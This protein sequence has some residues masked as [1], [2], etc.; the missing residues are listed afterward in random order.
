MR[1]HGLISNI[2]ATA[3]DVVNLLQGYPTNILLTEEAAGD[4]LDWAKDSRTAA[5]EWF[6]GRQP[7]NIP[8]VPVPPAMPID[9]GE[10]DTGTTY[11]MGI[12]LKVDR[13][14]STVAVFDAKRLPSVQETV[15]RLMEWAYSGHATGTQGEAA[16]KFAEGLL[17]DPRNTMIPLWLVKRVNP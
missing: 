7:V 17:Y 4:L 2:A 11:N 10:G 13:D 8:T 16:L 9:V 15:E 5:T 3:R 1:V 6:E 12:V 14:T